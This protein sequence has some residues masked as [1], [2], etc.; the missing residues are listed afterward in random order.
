MQTSSDYK[1]EDYTQILSNV[2]YVL[3]NSTETEKQIPLWKKA[4]NLY[5]FR[6]MPKWGSPKNESTAMEAS[7]ARPCGS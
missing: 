4:V 5:R 7:F 1:K 2:D 6:A 3:D